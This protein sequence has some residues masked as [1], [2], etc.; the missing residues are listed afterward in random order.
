MNNGIGM[1]KYIFAANTWM[2]LKT[3]LLCGFRLFLLGKPSWNLVMHSILQ[4]VDAL[5]AS[6]QIRCTAHN[7]RIAGFTK[8]RITYQKGPTFSFAVYCCTVSFWSFGLQQQSTLRIGR[9]EDRIQMIWLSQIG[10]LFRRTRKPV[11]QQGVPH[12]FRSLADGITGHT[13][14][15]SAAKFSG[16]CPPPLSQSWGS[17]RKISSHAGFAACISTIT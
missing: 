3:Q 16:L 1:Q 13:R 4:V 9:T 7:L 2:S 11:R 14:S 5:Y 17:N 12:S 6:L 10:S 8:H 15:S